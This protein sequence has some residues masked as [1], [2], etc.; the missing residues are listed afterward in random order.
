M[1]V[2]KETAVIGSH[3]VYIAL[4]GDVIVE[5]QAG[6]RLKLRNTSVSLVNLNPNVTGS[7]FPITIASINIDCLKL[8]P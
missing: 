8:L 3:V 4:N 6:Q 2:T 7:V 1:K 5:V